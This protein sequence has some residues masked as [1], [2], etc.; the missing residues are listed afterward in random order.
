MAR[1]NVEESVLTD[2]R[3]NQLYIKLGDI[4]K[5][6][7]SLVRAWRLAQKWY[8]TPERMIPVSEW[9]KNLIPK[10]II[11]VG[12]ADQIEGK[13]RVKGADDQFAWLIQRVES[14][15]KGGIAS[16]ISKR[17]SKSEII[18]ES[19]KHMLSG[20]KPLYSSLLIQE[21]IHMSS[22]DDVLPVL[23][24]IWNAHCH[25]FPKVRNCSSTRKRM[26]DARWRSNPLEAYWIEV[27]GRL[28]R[29][30]FCNGSNN[31]GWR[32]NFD[33]FIRP[34]THNKALEGFYDSRHAS[35]QPLVEK[36]LSEL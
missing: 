24:K 32:A 26:S 15:R 2:F 35:N 17:R 30:P 20:S 27:I 21:E 16:G 25:K 8:L 28:V 14:G 22:G 18:E 12:L 34:E 29:S 5:A 3:F 31:T 19:R 36:A 1:I 23:A 11:E 13:I 4:D 33:F 6:L 10:E 7:G 9:E